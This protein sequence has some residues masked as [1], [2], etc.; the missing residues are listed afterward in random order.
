MQGVWKT[1][2]CVSLCRR[3]ILTVLCAVDYR[4]PGRRRPNC[5][6]NRVLDLLYVL[7]FQSKKEKEYDLDLVE[8]LLHILL[9]N[10]IGRI[11]LV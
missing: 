11:I 1:G 7:C 9:C 5:G 4:V 2:S 6:G 10:L 8:N 3:S